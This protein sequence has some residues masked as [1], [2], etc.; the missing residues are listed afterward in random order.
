MRTASADL[1]QWISSPGGMASLARSIYPSLMQWS[2][3]Q[4]PSI[5][6]RERG[7]A[8]RAAWRS[9]QI[10]TTDMPFCSPMGCR[11]FDMLRAFRLHHVGHRRMKHLLLGEGNIELCAHL[12]PDVFVRRRWHRSA[13]SGCITGKRGHQMGEWARYCWRNSNNLSR[14]TGMTPMDRGMDSAWVWARC[15]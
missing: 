14:T 4:Y 13:S 7:G 1:V 5:F 10:L 2:S 8:G 9:A 12:L 11:T 3:R 6:A 15:H